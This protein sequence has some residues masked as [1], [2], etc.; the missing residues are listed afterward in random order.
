MVIGFCC[1][2]MAAP[3]FAQN[4]RILDG[5]EEQTEKKKNSDRD[6]GEAQEVLHVHEAFVRWLNPQ[7][8]EP[9]FGVEAMMLVSALALAKM[10]HEASGSKKRFQSNLKAAIKT[11]KTWSTKNFKELSKA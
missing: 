6:R 9:R 1:Y 4:R 3:A 11:L 5:K 2:V 8:V 10:A 7:D